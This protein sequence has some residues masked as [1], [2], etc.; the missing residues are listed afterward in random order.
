MVSRMSLFKTFCILA[1]VVLFVI[2]CGKSE[3]DVYF[4]E[5]GNPE[6]A[7]DGVAPLGAADIVLDGN[8]DDWKGVLPT[9]VIPSEGNSYNLVE[10]YAARDSEDNDLLYI[11]VDLGYDLESNV[12]N[13]NDAYFKQHPDAGGFYV[14][15]KLP[16][17]RDVSWHNVYV[18]RSLGQ[19]L[20]L[21]PRSSIYA[22]GMDLLPGKSNAHGVE[23]A[24][25][26]SGFEPAES[27]SLAYCEF[28]EN[29]DPEEIPDN[30]L[31]SDLVEVGTPIYPASL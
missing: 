13:Q 9:I 28:A 14:L 19:G 10:L 7:A 27:L 30:V 1:I 3:G 2:G 26:L 16:Q 23:L 25:D 31:H 11:R 20:W 21:D 5:S 8:F 4:V 18:S 22:S 6:S 24:I 29:L 17:F 15:F 12:L